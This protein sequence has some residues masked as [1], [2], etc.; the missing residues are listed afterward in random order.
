MAFQPSS[1]GNKG[2]SIDIEVLILEAQL[3]PKSFV[4]K[5]PFIGSVWFTAR[6]LRNETL[7]V[8]YD[9]L[10]DNPYHGEVWGNFTVSRKKRLLE[11]ARW[12]V[13]IDGVALHL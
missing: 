13:E 2:M 1:H 9:P 10:E 6:T 12:Y 11:A 4:T 5:P 8:G 3:D 7:K